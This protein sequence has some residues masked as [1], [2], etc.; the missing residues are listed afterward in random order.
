MKSL[1]VA[2]FFAAVITGCTSIPTANFQ[3]DTPIV[4]NFDVAPGYRNALYLGMPENGKIDLGI[5]IL[6]LNPSKRWKPTVYIS[7]NSE[8]SDVL[9]YFNISVDTDLKKIYG[10]ARLVNVKAEEVAS[11][12]TH[13]QLYSLT[14][15]IRLEA[16]IVGNNVSVY[17]NGQLADQQQL[18]YEPEMVELGASSGSFV[19]R[20]KLPPP[21]PTSE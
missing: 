2:S 15:E 21:P 18:T 11:S 9:Y 17:L 7:L 10:R 1:L 19:V 14:D 16:K 13:P 3:K 8:K 5:K 4:L 6:K 20:M 12:K